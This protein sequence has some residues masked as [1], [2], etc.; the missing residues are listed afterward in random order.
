M[1][2]QNRDPGYL[3]SIS[4]T[5]GAHL[6]L[7]EV[8]ESLKKILLEQFNVPGGVIFLY[9]SYADSIYVETAWG[10]PASILS[11]IKNLPSNALHYRQVIKEREPAFFSDFRDVIPYSVLDLSKI[12]PEWRSYVSIPLA[13]KGQVE[14]VLDLF[15]PKALEFTP[16]DIRMFTELGEQAGVAIQNARLFEQVLAGRRR[17]QLLSQELISVQEAERRR[18]ARELHDEIGQALTALKV[19]L[20]SIQRS[21]S[22]SILLPQLVESITIVEQTLQQVRNLSLDLRPSMLDDL[23]VVSALRW[24]IDRQAQRGGFEAEFTADLPVERLPSEMETTCFRIV[25]E[26]LTNVIRHAQ[27]K[28]VWVSLRRTEGVLELQINDDGIGFDVDAVLERMAG[29]QSLGL[30]G[31]QERVQ[32]IGGDITISSNALGT[33]ILATFPLET[34]S[35][36]QENLRDGD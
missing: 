15:R 16:N 1:L 26:A 14:G 25:Q 9:D 28:H 19:N 34:P 31:M 3:N 7:S 35:E 17:L 8:L 4:A 6:S 18:I 27:A 2:R 24:Y 21:L 10:V 36:Q 29:R 30:L 32:L 33:K 23:G 12:R 13:A 22:E 11:E 5:V 20:Q